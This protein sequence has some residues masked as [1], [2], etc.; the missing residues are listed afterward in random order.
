MPDFSL[1]HGFF[2]NSLT[3]GLASPLAA[4]EYA[5]QW[6]LQ[7]GYQLSGSYGWAIILLSLAVNIC[8]IPAFSFAEILQERER[9][10]QRRFQPKLDEFRRAFSGASLHAVRRTYYRQQNYHP[11]SGLRSSLGLL[12]QI[13]FFVAAYNLLSHYPA[14][15]GQSFGFLQDLMQPDQLL[16]ILD[17]R[18]NLLPFLMSVLNLWAAALYGSKLNRNERRQIYWLALAFFVLLYNAPSALLLYWNCNNLF[19]VC[20]NWLGQKF[21]PNILGAAAAAP[22]K[23]VVSKMPKKLED[24]GFPKHKNQ[25]FVHRFLGVARAANRIFIAVL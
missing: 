11:A 2:A 19:S 18:F 22:S 23:N 12:L 20:K 16:P 9:R 3:N 17:E 14:F 4:L 15:R 24:S 6:L 8:L 10:L 5:M 7:L 1:F 21:A 13:P 25:A